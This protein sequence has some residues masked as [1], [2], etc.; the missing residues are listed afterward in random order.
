[1]QYIE[2]IFDQYLEKLNNI[3]NLFYVA[4]TII[5]GYKLDKNWACFK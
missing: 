4:N 5:D 2:N 3:V 1:M